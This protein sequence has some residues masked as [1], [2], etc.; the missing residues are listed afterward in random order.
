MT[1][2]VEKLFYTTAEVGT[3]FGVSPET[4]RDWL[5]AGKIVGVKIGAEWRVCKAELD[6]LAVEKYGA[7]A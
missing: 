3:I 6:R 1:T 4:I 2:A 7:P 5:N